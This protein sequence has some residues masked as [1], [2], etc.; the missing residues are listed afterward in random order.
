VLDGAEATSAASDSNVLIEGGGAWETGTGQRMQIINTS[1]AT[2]ARTI[3][4]N[5]QQYA[6]I[7]NRKTNSWTCYDSDSTTSD[8]C[9]YYPTKA[10]QIVIKYGLKDYTTGSDG[11]MRWVHD[12]TA[13]VTYQYGADE[14]HWFEWGYGTT[15]ST[16]WHDMQ[17]LKPL[18]PQERL[19]QILKQRQSPLL[20]T[21]SKT[22]AVTHGDER[23]MRARQ[24]L[25]MIVGEE[26]FQRFIRRG[27]VT[28]HN[29]KSGYTYQIFHSSHHLTHV[30]KNG[31]MVQRLCIYLKGNFPPTD[32]VI[33]MYLLAINND[34]RIW[35]VGVK[36]PP[37]QATQREEKLIEEPKSLV[38]I[39]NELKG[40]A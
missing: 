21:G 28:A 26:K 16:C 37:I 20:R 14:D 18:T 4:K 19:A 15:A 11:Y 25:R 6:R 36:N 35:Q 40:V 39:Y 13:S 38:E 34:D 31:K 10:Q 30:W 9:E 22:R 5:M 8:W 27:F 29:K 2:E 23:E 24:T 3:W 1:S 33:T 17:A 12:G 7:A 32:F